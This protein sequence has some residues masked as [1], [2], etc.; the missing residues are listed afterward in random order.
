MRQLQAYTF[1]WAMLWH[2][3]YEVHR[4]LP[5]DDC[6]FVEHMITDFKV[7]AIPGSFFGSIDDRIRFCFGALDTHDINELYLRLKDAV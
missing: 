2:T 5:G 4:A 3:Q 6:L 7:S 1:E